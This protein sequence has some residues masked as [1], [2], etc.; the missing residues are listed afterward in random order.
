MQILKNHFEDI[1]IEKSQVKT[2]DFSVSPEYDYLEHGKVFRGFAGQQSLRIEMP[3]NREKLNAAFGVIA[4]SEADPYI[5]LH[6]TTSEPEK[7]R[8]Q[9]LSDAVKNC[10]GR[11]QTL[12][13]AS[14]TSL[15]KILRIDY[16]YTEIV[17]SSPRYELRGDQAQRSSAPDIEPAEIE[18][19]DTVTM[20]WELL[21]R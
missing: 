1:G 9:V 8:E 19:E 15:G 7:I 5:R 2:T 11:A 18:N 12:A 17:V 3:I 20:T 13:Q 10:V 4:N 14:G 21:Q 6:F 16:G